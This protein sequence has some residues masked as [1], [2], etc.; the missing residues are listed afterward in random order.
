MQP[1]LSA[2]NRLPLFSISATRD[3]EVHAAQ[4]LP[5]HT[6]MRRAGESVARLALALAP[7]AQCIWVAAGP[8]N[9]GGDGLEAAIWLKHLGKNVHV[10]WVRDARPVPNDAQAAM[11]RAIAAGIALQPSGAPELGAQ[12]IAIDALLGIGAS[13]SPQGSLALLIERLNMLPCPVLA[14]D[15]PSGLNADT[16]LALG[17][18]CVKATQTLSLLTLK[19]GLFTAAG[20]DHAG[21]VWLD[22]L[23]VAPQPANPTAWLAGRRSVGAVLPQRQHAQHKGSFGD[24]AVVGGA[25]GMTGAALLA[26]RAAHAA[27][28]GRVFVNLL[29]PCDLALDVLRPELMFRPEWS[30]GE[31]APLA[32]TTVVCGCGGGAVVAEVLPRLLG[33]VHRLVL[34][35][36][37]LNAIA[38]DAALQSLLSARRAA[39]QLTVLTPHP[40]EAARLLNQSTASVQADRLAASTTLARRFDCVVLLKGSG[41][42]VASPD[43]IA[44]I[45][46]TGNASLASAGTGDVLAGWLGGV[47]S[48]CGD[49]GGAGQRT[50]S[51]PRWALDAAV[52]SAFIH[53][54]AAD[55]AAVFPLRASDLIDRIQRVQNQLVGA[56]RRG[57]SDGE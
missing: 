26:A 25:P 32:H 38:S 46:P 57:P 43:D 31:A 39:G 30:Q 53:G 36:D 37:A 44:S 10:T 28:A 7:H 5:P 16:G 3:I 56:P 12:D 8:G 55:E 2:D 15:V 45:N 23:R 20:R 13:R 27:G 14:V 47:W 19:P 17:D 24:V 9:N 51:K 35:A 22:D 40:L 41:T 34:D 4:A 29:G 11:A 52:A 33:A 6:L 49:G 1:V 21:E 42:V 54:A 50:Q 48:Q 18:T